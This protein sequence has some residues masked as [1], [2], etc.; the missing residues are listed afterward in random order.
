VVGLF[1]KNDLEPTIGKTN[2]DHIPVITQHTNNCPSVVI[3]RKQKD[4]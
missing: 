3:E 1:K 4:K 2:T